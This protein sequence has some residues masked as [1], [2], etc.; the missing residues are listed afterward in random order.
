MDILQGCC[1]Q[2]RQTIHALVKVEPFQ[3]A[4][5]FASTANLANRRGF[6]PEDSI[7][8]ISNL[9]YHP[10]RQFLLKASRWLS[11]LGRDLPIQHE[12]NGGDFD[13]QFQKNDTFQDFIR[14][15]EFQPPL[16]PREALYGGRTNATRLY[17]CEGDMRYVDVC[18]LY[19]YVLKYKPFP[20]GQPEII[21]EDFQDVRSYLE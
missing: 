10:A 19:P 11:W 12:W 21:T 8:I 17:C 4:I 20:L 7:A 13:K 5:T 15:L 2:F 9:G 3:E 16:N 6:M 1:V 14:E 18:S